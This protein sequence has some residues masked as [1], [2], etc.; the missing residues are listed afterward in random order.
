MAD[1]YQLL[2]VSPHASVA[3]IRQAYARRARE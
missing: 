1:Y 2:G 3:E